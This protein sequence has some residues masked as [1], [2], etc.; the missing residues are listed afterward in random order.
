MA[1]KYKKQKKKTAL[2]KFLDIL[3]KI[4]VAIAVIIFGFIIYKNTD[5]S[6]PS[7]QITPKKTS[8]NR[9]AYTPSELKW[10][11]DFKG[12]ENVPNKNAKKSSSGGSNSGFKYEGFKK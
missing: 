12:V 3:F 4:L 5:F 10:F 6:T 9:N 11:D 2:T 8:S 1:T 7:M